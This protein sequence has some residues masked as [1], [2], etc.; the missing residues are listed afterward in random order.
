MNSIVFLFVF[1]FTIS[2]RGG[3]SIIGSNK[4]ESIL[5]NLTE[6]DTLKERQILY[7]GIVWENKY[8]RIKEDQ[9]LFSNFFLPGTISINGRTFKNL[10]IRYDIFSDE[11]TIPINLEEIVQLNKEMVD[12][13]T[14]SFED[15]IYRFTNILNDTLKSFTG[16][17]KL[18]YKGSSAFYVKYKKSISPYSTPKSDVLFRT[19]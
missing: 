2:A 15:K 12:S 13:F 19:T 3:L 7:N 6:Q 18:L 1:L 14:L 17:I 8:H 10:R 4:P 11:I 5:S 16:Y 9:F